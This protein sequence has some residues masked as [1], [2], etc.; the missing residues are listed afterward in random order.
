MEL[1]YGRN[2]PYIFPQ[3]LFP[4]VAAIL[5]FQKPKKNKQ[6]NTW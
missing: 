4:A 1:I 6:T 2:V 3:A 5:D